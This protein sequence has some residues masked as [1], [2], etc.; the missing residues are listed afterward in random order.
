LLVR[1]TRTQ[2][3]IIDLFTKEIKIV[4]AVN[5]SKLPEQVR[6]YLNPRAR[7]SYFFDNCE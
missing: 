2:A 6:E 7:L 3:P 4:N 1:I 5:P